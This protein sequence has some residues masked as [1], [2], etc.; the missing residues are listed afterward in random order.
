MSPRVLYVEDNID[1][2]VLVRRV[3]R[4]AGFELLEATSAEQGISMA[5]KHLPD[6]ILMDINMPE[7]DGLTATMRLR[8]N[9]AL[10]SVPIVALTAN[11]MRNVLD[12]VMASGCDGYIVK[13]IQVDSFS[14]QILSF[15]KDGQR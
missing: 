15:L 5:E 9:P 2:L 12:Q 8:E 7:M 4:A 3:L 11:V 14:D 6:L 1:N 10:R 13:P